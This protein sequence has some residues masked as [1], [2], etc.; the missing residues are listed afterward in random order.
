MSEAPEQG[1]EGDGKKQTVLSIG[2]YI[3]GSINEKDPY[4]LWL[5][6]LN[7]RREIENIHN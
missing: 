4:T 1:K 5:P 2:S 6:E 3:I 7:L